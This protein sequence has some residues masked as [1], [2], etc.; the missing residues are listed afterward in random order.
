MKGALPAPP[1]AHA[2]VAET[3]ATPERSSPL[4]DGFG[5]GTICHVW[6]HVSVAALAA[7]GRVAVVTETAARMSAERASP[8]RRPGFP[9]RRRSTDGCASSHLLA[10]APSAQP[11]RPKARC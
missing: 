7:T 3:D 6:L 8:H 11:T 2:S 5:L 4:P 9:S 1:T 10:L